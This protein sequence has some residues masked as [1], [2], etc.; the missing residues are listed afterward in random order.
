MTKNLKILLPAIVLVQLLVAA[1]MGLAHDEAY[2]WLFSHNLD[3]GYF[4]HPPMVAV[5]IRIFSFLPHSSLSL[6]LGFILMQFG[7]LWF[8]W[9]LIPL[10]KRWFSALLFFAFPLASFSGLFA[11]PDMPLLFVS[12]LYC[13]FLQDYL[14]KQTTS[15]SIVLGL[16][17]AFLLYSKYHGILLVFFT[18]LALPKLFN[19]KH[20]YLVAFIA[21][22]FFLPHVWWQ[23]SHQFATIK[24]HFLERPSS[25]F[26]LK[27]SLEYLVLQIFLAGVF[28]G[29]LLWYKIAKYK[30]VNDFDR[31]MKFI[32]FGVVIFFF[33]STFS[34]KFEANWTVFLTVSLI[35]LASVSSL[36]DH[37]WIKPLIVSSFVIVM[38]ARLLLVLPASIVPIKRLKE[39]QGWKEFSL[40]IKQRCQGPVLANTYQI[41]SK[42]SFYLQEP[43]H[44]LNFHSR[45]NQ[46]DFWIP[47]E[48][49]Y[50]SPKLCYLT[51]K[52]QFGGEEILSPEG[53]KLRLIKDFSPAEL[54]DFKSDSK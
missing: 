7:T 15:I 40:Q 50:L 21:F 24:Y 37:K 29:P 32:T 3:W 11:L 33:I 34:K 45:K 31:V 22:L 20:F 51:D 2:Y 23:Y 48:T 52:K 54:T 26:S 12:A 35:Y 42:L 13:Y 10:E 38:M 4:D 19:Q 25:D 30:S 28:V 9:K 17:I 44:A 6:R 5:V 16:T 8:L 18:L 49:Y 14:R 53:K 47:N 41:A 39:F 43:I 46:F 27:R 36:S 1:L